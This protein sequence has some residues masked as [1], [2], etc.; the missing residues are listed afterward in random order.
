[1]INFFS[2][3]ILPPVGHLNYWQ[4]LDDYEPNVVFNTKKIDKQLKQI[5]I[6]LSMLLLR[7]VKINKSIE[8][9]SFN[10]FIL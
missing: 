7:C 8:V 9:K 6:L 4:Q 10:V 1:M 5:L 3:Q 2:F